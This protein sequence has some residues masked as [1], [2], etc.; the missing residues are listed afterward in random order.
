MRYCSRCLLEIL[1]KEWP[2]KV[3]ATINYDDM[4][5]SAFDTNGQIRFYSLARHALVNALK[6]AGIHEGS[7]ILLPAFLC[8]DLLAPVNILGAIPCWYEVNHDLAPSLPPELWPLADAVLMIDYFGFPQNLALFKIYA[9]RT[10]AV[11]IEDNAHGFLSRDES[12]KLLGCRADLGIFSIRKTLR[13][14]DGAALWVKSGCSLAKLPEQLPFIGSGVNPAQLKKFYIR[15]LPVV[16][17]F[18]YKALTKFIRIFRVWISLARKSSTDSCSESSISIAPEPWSGLLPTLLRLDAQR[19]IKRRRSS[20][21]KCSE[22]CEKIG[23]VSVFPNLPPSCAPYAYAFRGDQYVV[24]TMQKYAD[25][26]G[27]DLVS[28]PDLPEATIRQAPKYYQNIFLINLT[29]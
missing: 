9:E 13:I 28:W 23:G 1:Q 16:G 15:S 8:R 19:E 24:A 12:G 3:S 25:H 6:I 14:P 29:W 18:I 10:H 26:N 17:E 21:L 5:A 22:E 2:T 7:R 27:L 20:Y 11:I 4:I